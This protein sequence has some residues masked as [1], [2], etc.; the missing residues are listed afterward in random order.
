MQLNMYVSSEARS[1]TSNERE[2]E[3]LLSPLSNSSESAR[4]SNMRVAE[5]R[6]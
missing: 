5:H 4:M 1:K 3:E 2:R 6:R